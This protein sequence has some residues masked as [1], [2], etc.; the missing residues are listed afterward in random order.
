M[1]TIQELI[2][3]NCILHHPL[4]GFFGQQDPKPKVQSQHSKIAQLASLVCAVIYF[5]YLRLLRFVWFFLF[6]LRLVRLIK[7]NS[8]S[9]FAELRSAFRS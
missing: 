4:A 3:N 2:S 1:I 5:I 9:L 7:A 8:S 6:V